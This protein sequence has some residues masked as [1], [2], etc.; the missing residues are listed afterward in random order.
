MITPRV[1]PIDQP[2]PFADHE[3]FFSLTDRRGLIRY[4]NEVFTRVAGYTEQEMLGKPHNLIRHPD[5]PRSVFQLFWNY[6]EAGKTIA[7]YVKNLAADGRY[8]WVLAV[9]TPCEGG[10][11]SV[12]LK[13]NGPLFDAARAAYAETLKLETTLEAEQGKTY[14][15]EQSLEHLSGLIA[16][17]GFDSYDEF[18]R[19]ALNSELE[20][21]ATLHPAEPRG[22]GIASNND[23]DAL[24]RLHISLTESA[25][26]LE[27]VFKSL[28]VLESLSERLDGKQKAMEELGPTLTFLALNTHISAS[29]LGAEGAVL[30]VVSRSLGERSKEAE[31]LINDLIRRI[32]PSCAMARRIAFDVGVA[33]L[34]ARV[35]ESFVQE[36]RQSS[37]AGATGLVGE[38][39]DILIAE[40]LVRCKSTI[41]A[42]GEIR[43]DL[44]V[45]SSL[46]RDLMAEVDHMKIVQLNGKIDIAAR[47]NASGFASIFDEVADIVREARHDCEDIIE[48]LA[49][50]T[51]SLADLVPTERSLQ[52]ELSRVRETTHQIVGGQPE[53]AG[54]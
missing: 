36:L 54:V 28:D 41:T 20:S 33:Q 37:E 32:K 19:A 5:V 1:T 16:D 3:L 42:L 25:C 30:S 18:M 12:R 26:D 21:R 51:E 44:A 39:L 22:Q 50:T 2:R 43:A 14:A 31:R 49:S 46:A 13:P 38:S 53:L 4:G 35:C 24:D 10:Y 29:S 11:V 47:P 27:T 17:H 48:L 8:Y 9:A 45:M 40:F 23:S 6:L 34:E 15:I 7:A 52:D